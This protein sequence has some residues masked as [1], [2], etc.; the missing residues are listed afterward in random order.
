MQ[1]LFTRVTWSLLTGR[2]VPRGLG[3][4]LAEGPGW[5]DR[6]RSVRQREVSANSS[7][8]PATGV[9]ACVTAKDGT[10][11]GQE[12]RVCPLDGAV[13]GGKLTSEPGAL[14]GTPISV[15]L[16]RVGSQRQTPSLPVF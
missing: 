5:W 8:G 13:R 6:H 7:S 9:T 16:Q 4:L 11:C 15:L 10:G 14:T 3:D 1:A 2:R 12:R